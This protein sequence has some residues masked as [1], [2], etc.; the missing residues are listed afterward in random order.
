MTRDNP[1]PL[2]YQ[3]AEQLR[4]RIE[5]NT[6]KVGDP[7]PA[8]PELGREFKVSRMTVRR[9]VD[10]LASQGL[11]VKKQGRG[12]FVVAGRVTQ[13]LNLVTSWTETMQSRGFAIETAELKVEKVTPPA[14][15]A[16]ALRLGT[17]EQVY[18]VERL[19]LADG[20]PITIMVNYLVEEVGRRLENRDL[21]SGSLYRVLEDDL[22]VRIGTAEEIVEARLATRSE[23]VRLRIPRSSAM[24]QVTRVT[25]DEEGKP[26]EVAI[27]SSRA[28]RYRYA[29]SLRG[30]PKRTL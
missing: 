3:V 6:Y 5:E 10:E 13:A 19:R 23:S 28:D 15:I 4:R 9:A 30:R 2:Y 18:R 14:K 11:V 22:G 25:Y 16:E 1:M 20:E 12:T 29:V 7:I 8:E 21:S 27:V 24:I 17:G 26:F